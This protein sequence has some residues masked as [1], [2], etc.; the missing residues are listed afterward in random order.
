MIHTIGNLTLL[1]QG[2]NSS[3][4]NGPFAAKRPAIA[5][6]ST[7]RLNARFQDPG[8]SKWNEYDIRARGEELFAEAI[9]I[10]PRAE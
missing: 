9:M 5:E 1:T 3:V 7:L 4:S 2:L 6:H 10:W 8:K